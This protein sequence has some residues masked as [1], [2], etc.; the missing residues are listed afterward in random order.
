MSDLDFKK[1]RLIKGHGLTF[2]VPLIERLRAAQRLPQAVVKVLSYAHGTK[3][4][5]SSID[6]ISR[7]G[8]LP[9]ETESGDIIQGRE[10]QNAL[11]Q[12]WSRDFGT[13]KNNRD[14]VHIAFSMPKGS[15]PEALRKAVR[16]VL[17][18]NFQD[19]E[20][21]FT[22]H[23]DTAY[24]HAHTIIKMRSRETGKQLRINQPEIHQLREAFAEAAREQGVHLGASPRAARGVGQKGTRQAIH[25]LRR[26]GI[27][28]KVDKQAVEEAIQ[29]VERG[30]WQEKVW[31]QAMRER[32]ER[33]RKAY[34]SEA[35][36][37]R[38]AAAQENIAKDQKT[39]ES[40][41]KAAADLERF[42][43]EMPHPK[44]RRQILMEKI[45]K[46]LGI[47][48]PREI[49]RLSRDEEMER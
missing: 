37:L 23:K 8:T 24:P 6:Y 46:H 5:K 16:K 35:Q 25:H 45:G 3:G 18:T 31:E 22:I 28:P 44:S 42:S 33:E 2:P 49:Y 39:Q 12:N 43:R 9:L 1:Y 20:S 36:R 30:S 7:E 26:R 21:V 4:V 32:N 48:N 15:N 47:R 29:G 38:A 40:F 11:V 27:V 17:S 41:R 10:E 19:H 34:L 14:S 13:R